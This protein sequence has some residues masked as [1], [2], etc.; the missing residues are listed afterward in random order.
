VKLLL[1]EDNPDDIAIV[2]RLAK[3]SPLSIELTAL[4]NGVQALDW[5]KRGEHRPDLILLDL[6]LPGLRGT[7]VLRRIRSNAEL[8]DVPVIVVS[9]SQDDEDILEG[10]RLG[11]H[12]HIVKPIARD[13]FT[14]IVASVRK[15][16]PRLKALRCVQEGR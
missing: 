7:D 1:I 11:A 2:N 13:D 3:A 14:W 9:G 6:G 4:P 16:R 10:L 15:L 12:S 5:M 8:N